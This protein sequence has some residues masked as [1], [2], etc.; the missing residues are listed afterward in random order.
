M[1]LVIDNYDSFVYNLARYFELLGYKTCVFRNDAI[2]LNTI[3]KLKPQAI[4]LSP[5][6]CAPNDAGICLEVIKRFAPSIPILGICLGHQ[7]IGQAF[8]ARIK[9]AAQPR[10]GKS[11]PVHHTGHPMFK[12][13][14]KS[15]S[16]GRY[17]SLV[18]EAV[19]SPLMVLAR[20][21][22][23]GEIMAIAHCQW[24]VIGLQFHPESLLTPEGLKML[25]N[26]I[27]FATA[28]LAQD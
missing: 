3:A 25:D 21:E 12:S 2:S 10:H 6:P 5:G 20:S 23:D 16:V 22:D 8:G 26:Y 11:S 4:V 7:A 17:H 24:P 19:A 14:P 9:R 13:I 28:S 15:F 1:I 18:L 27:R